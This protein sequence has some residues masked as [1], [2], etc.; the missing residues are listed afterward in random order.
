MA[1]MP[2]NYWI[3]GSAFRERNDDQ[4]ARFLTHGVWEIDRPSASDQAMVKA[5][6]P[7]DRIAIKSTF[8]QKHGLPFN[9]RGQSVSVLRIKARGTITANPSDGERVSVAWDSEY[10]GGD[11]YFFTYRGTIWQLPQDSEPA[12]RLIQFIFAGEP[13]DYDWFLAQPHWR[14]KY[15][16]A[17]ELAPPSV[18]IEKTLVAGRADREGGDHALGKALWSPQKSKN[19][20]DIYAN[21]RRVEPGDVI[22]HLTDNR[23][24]TGVS[25]AA[26][27]A[28]DTFDGLVGTEWEGPCYR[29]ALCDYVELD[30]PLLRDQVFRTEPFAAELGEL[31]ESGAKGLFFNRKLELN[32]GAYLTEATPTLLSILNRAYVHAAGKPLPWMDEEETAKPTASLA[33]SPYSPEDALQSLFLEAAEIDAILLLWR[34]KKNIVLQG[35]PGVGKSFAASKLAFALMG[36]QARDRMEF[37]QFHQSYAYEELT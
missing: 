28:D 32:Q 14:D 4:T 17:D 5:M 26:E 25:I 2:L 1:S 30:P 35:P 22:L 8:V 15:I 16:G 19:G 9:N 20:G 37:V 36:Q 33:A 27:R 6:Q 3:V 24:F 34:A 29:I 12:E 31:V 7:G 13:Q 21:M 18:W 10:K 23:G 11:W